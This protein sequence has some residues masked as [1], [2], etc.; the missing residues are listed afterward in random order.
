MF[1]S[2]S[3]VPIF[4]I[5]SFIV[6]FAVLGYFNITTLLI[7]FSFTFVGILW[8]IY[9]INKKKILDFYE[10]QLKSKNQESIFEIFSGIRDIKLFQL[11]N[12][13]YKILLF[14]RMCSNV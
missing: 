2:F 12:F 10:F 4:S 11:E 7:Y 9:W 5:F 13:R 14:F 3:G 1:H 6:F 8:S